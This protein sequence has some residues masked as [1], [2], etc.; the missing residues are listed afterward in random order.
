MHREFSRN[1]PSRR[2]GSSGDEVEGVLA[3]HE[4]SPHAAHHVA[5]LLFLLGEVLLLAVGLAVGAVVVLGLLIFGHLGDVEF[6]DTDA[7][8][9]ESGFEVAESVAEEFGGL[10]VGGLEAGGD[11]AVADFDAD[12]HSAQVWG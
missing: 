7:L 6:F 4:A 5:A 10:V 1:A 2:Q 9:F 12:M 3:F 11:G 8:G